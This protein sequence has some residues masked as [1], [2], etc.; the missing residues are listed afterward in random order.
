MYGFNHSVNEL[1]DIIES[2]IERLI[3]ERI[4]FAMRQQVQSSPIKTLD[5]ASFYTSVSNDKDDEQALSVLTRHH[6]ET[7]DLSDDIG[8]SFKHGTIALVD[9]TANKLR[10]CLHLTE[11]QA[12]VAAQVVNVAMYTQAERVTDY[13]TKLA[14]A[15]ITNYNNYPDLIMDEASR[16]YHDTADRLC[17]LWNDVNN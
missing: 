9:N 7:I 10:E 13:S 4:P 2:S 14:A 15:G 5:T 17:D 8:N 12:I 1:N 16:A 6:N 11:K 3:A